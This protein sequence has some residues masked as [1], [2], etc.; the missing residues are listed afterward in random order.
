MAR[1]TPRFSASRTVREYTEEHY[2]PAA[3]A[4]QLRSAEQGAIANTIAEWRH[5]VEQGW[6]S[7]RF[8][9]LRVKTDADHHLIEVDLLLEDV[10]PNAVHVELYADAV[11]DGDPIRQTM[12]WAHALPDAS[13]GGVYRATVPAT[14]PASDYT[15]RVMPQ[16]PGM[17]VP[18][19]CGLI[20]W[21]R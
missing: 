15:A 21:Q 16:H 14:R 12:T 17:A 20:L 1:L 3:T 6:R 8:G 18:L 5:T 19:E 11:H 13:R 10:D 9:A 4:Y 7:L 2:L